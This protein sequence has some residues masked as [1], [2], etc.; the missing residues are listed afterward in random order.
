MMI[1]VFTK[2]WQNVKLLLLSSL[3]STQSPLYC[4]R[5]FTHTNSNGSFVD[6]KCHLV[7]SNRYRHSL[8][9]TTDLL[10]SRQRCLLW[11]TLPICPYL[12]KMSVVITLRG[13]SWQWWD[14]NPRLLRDWSLNPAPSTARPHYHG[15]LN[16]VL[17]LWDYG[18]S[19]VI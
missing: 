18:L 19:Y 12:G 4:M 9:S 2:C 7:I 10:V 3:L 14:L 13:Y 11:E 5:T 17:C 1:C 8:G 16:K 6:T 15:N